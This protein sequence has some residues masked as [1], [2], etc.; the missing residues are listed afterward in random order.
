[1]TYYE[2]YDPVKTGNRLWVDY[3][4]GYTGYFGIRGLLPTWTCSAAMRLRASVMS[5]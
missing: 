1:M 3:S 5:A 2:Y 4:I